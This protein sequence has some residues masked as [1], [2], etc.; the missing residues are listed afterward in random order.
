M[1]KASTMD[2]YQIMLRICMI[3]VPVFTVLA[4]L[5]GFGWN[6]YG[7]KIKEQEAVE[8]KISETKSDSSSTVNN[9]YNISGDVVQGDKNTVIE[10]PSNP[11]TSKTTVRKTG[12][13]V[14]LS[15]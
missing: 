1:I 13:S 12:P 9:V 15:E 2:N 4:A 11:T 14:N 7:L 6:Y 8:K 5:C 10:Q 3:G